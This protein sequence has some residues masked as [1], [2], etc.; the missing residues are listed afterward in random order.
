MQLDDFHRRFLLAV[1]Q[2]RASGNGRDVGTVRVGGVVGGQRHD[3]F[4]GVVHPLDI[5]L[6]KVDDFLDT[7]CAVGFAEGSMVEVNAAIDDANHHTLASVC[8]PQL[9]GS[10]G[11]GCVHLRYVGGLVIYRSS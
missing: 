10:S 7:C 1:V 11:S 6:T 8:L 3:G 9:L 2:V 4:F 5:F